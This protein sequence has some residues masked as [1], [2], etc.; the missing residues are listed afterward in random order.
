MPPG[1]FN[2][3]QMPPGQQPRP[4]M[5]GGA[6]STAAGGPTPA[7]SAAGKDAVAAPP[8]ERESPQ[9]AATV[10]LPTPGTQAAP[11]GQTGPPPPVESK[12]DTVAAPAPAAPPTGDAAKSVVNGSKGGRFI[13]A[14]PLPGPA[15]QSTTTSN[16]P[17]RQVVGNASQPPTAESAAAK[18]VPEAPRAAPAIRTLEEANRDARA[19]VAAAM[20]KLPP[21]GQQKKQDGAVDNLAKK[22]GEMRTNDNMRAPRQPGTGGYGAGHRGG[23]GGHRG[24]REQTRRTEVPKEDYDFESANA[25]FNKQDL[26]KEA[27]ASGSP[28][29]A[30]TE[31][32]AAN[33]TPP[34]NGVDGSGKSSEANVTIPQGVSYNKNASFF[35]DISS[36]IKD[37]AQ[38]DGQKM[39]AREYRNE[40]RQKNIETFGQGSVDA[41][42]RSGYGRGRGRGRGY[43]RGR[44][45][46]SYEG[47]GGRGQRNGARSD[48]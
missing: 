26:A 42:Y 13:P 36:E 39:G 45:R 15:S 44:G 22:V 17:P 10:K 23:R 41:G 31:D 43:G 16:G 40:E 30:S 20:A 28:V 29:A 34:E 3:P 48:A 12:P 11:R 4:Q 37:R 14:V 47:R 35:D 8:P 19:A 1:Q 7:G 24:G 18:P 46:G 27:L 5:S 6:P 33:G 9:P 2:P 25:K 21:A 32:A 38:N